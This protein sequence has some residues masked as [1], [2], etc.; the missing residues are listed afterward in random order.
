MTDGATLTQSGGARAMMRQFEL[1]ERVK[2]Y[3][4]SVDEDALNKAYVF[5]MKAHGAQMRASGDPYFSHPVEV[6]GILS[7]MKLDSASIVTGLL[8]DTVEDT[9]ATLED[10]EKRFG[11]EIARLVDGVT[12]L[13]RIELQS[14]GGR[15]TAHDGVG[16]RQRNG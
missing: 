4:P 16:Q 6:A 2:S 9:L 12:K 3:D 10:I 5:S 13:S 8:H 1:V 15:K 7:R 14:D 11:P